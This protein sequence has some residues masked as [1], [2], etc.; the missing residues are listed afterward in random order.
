MFATR[1]VKQGDTAGA[2]VSLMALEDKVILLVKFLGHE[3]DD[4][5]GMVAEFSHAYIGVLKQMAPPDCRQKETIKV[6]IC[7]NLTE[8]KSAKVATCNL[9]FDKAIHTVTSY[10]T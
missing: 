8:P 9:Y 7:A 2:K 3:D 6:S 1:L 5:S 10:P 4:V